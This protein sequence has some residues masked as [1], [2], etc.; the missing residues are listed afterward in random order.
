M[1]HAQPAAGGSSP[2]LSSPQNP[3]PN[4]QV[5]L[6]KLD[7]ATNTVPS[8]I[9]NSG[10]VREARFVATDPTNVYSALDGGVHALYTIQGR[11]DAPGCTLAQPNFAFQQSYGNVIFRIPTPVFGLGLV[12]NTPDSTLRANLNSTSSSRYNLG[13]GGS[14]NTS[15]N[16]GTITRFGWKAQNKSLLIFAS[17]AYNVEQ[18]VTNEGFPNERNTTAGCAF[19]ATP[20]DSSNLLNPNQSSSNFGTTVGTISGDVVGR[21]EFC[22]VHAAA[23]AAHARAAKLFYH[24][25]PGVVQPDRLQPLPFAESHHG[26]VE[27]HGDVERDL[28]PLLRFR[29]PSYG[30]G[31]IRRDQSRRSRSRSIPHRT[32]VGTGPTALLPP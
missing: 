17:E 22:A 2:G 24:Q 13:I 29:A 32:L 4:P 20:E 9:T 10:P 7:G 28:S 3:V 31:I 6:A 25:W 1:C 12:E 23:G 8:F 11:T 26:R 5:A 16:D 15:G 27:F 30:C 19:N 18:G 21:R 14:F